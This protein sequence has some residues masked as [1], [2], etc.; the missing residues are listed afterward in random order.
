M[1]IELFGGCSAVSVVQIRHGEA[2]NAKRNGLRIAEAVVVYRERNYF[3]F[4]LESMVMPPGPLSFFSSLA[5]RVPIALA[6]HSLALATSSF[7][8]AG[9]LKSTSA[10]R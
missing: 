7:T 8:A 6:V 1:E 2:G 5:L 3:R 4:P 9:S 10:L